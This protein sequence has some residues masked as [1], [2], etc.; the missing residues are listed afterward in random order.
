MSGFAKYDYVDGNLLCE[1]VPLADIAKKQGTPFY[2]YSHTA[3]EE[4]YRHFDDA[5]KGVSHLICFSMKAN[6]NAA[7]LKT[8]FNLGGGADVVSGGEL[9]RALKA[10]CDPQKTVF[11]G[12]GKTSEE[13]HLALGEGILQFNVESE[14]EL[15]NIQRIAAFLDKRAPIAIRVNPDVDPKTHPY[16]STGLKQ[17]KFGVSQQKA[18]EMY[19]QA[20][21]MSHIDLVGI[22]C[23]IGSQL[24]DVT[25]FTDALKKVRELVNTLKDQGVFLRNIDIGGGLGIRYKDEA[26]KTPEEYAA[27]VLKPIEDL[28]LRVIL[29][30]GRFLVGNAGALVTKVIYTKEN[31]DGHKFTII[32]AAFNDLM[33]PA[34]Y[35]AYHEILPVQRKDDRKQIVTD[36]V[37]PIC[38]TGDT[39]SKGRTLQQ[40]APGEL[41]AIMSAGAYG[42]SMASTYNSRGR[43]SEILVKDRQYYVVR[44]PE[45]LEDIMGKEDLPEFLKDKG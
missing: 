25:P 45:R 22:D 34:L 14:Q 23:H 36:I 32:D 24:T 1:G 27:A 40:T 42:M 21:S 8:F 17:N 35:D 12:V 31:D 16:I 28:G 2:V 6:S 13:I 38:E 4:Q 37:G 29:E 5:F 7:I 43:C 33:R 10:G 15:A 41:L 19:H 39:F 18:L 9:R 11:S 3:L 30:P 20:R 44:K 26:V